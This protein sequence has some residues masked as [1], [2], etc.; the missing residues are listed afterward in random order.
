MNV[1][2]ACWS[3]TLKEPRQRIG[4][5]KQTKA[6]KAVFYSVEVRQGAEWKKGAKLEWA[7]DHKWCIHYQ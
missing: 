1:R 3:K 4:Q 6:R 5:K 2:G 7:I